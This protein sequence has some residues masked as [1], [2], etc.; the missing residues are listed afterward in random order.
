MAGR[1]VESRIAALE[2]RLARARSG[3]VESREFRLVDKAGRVRAAVEMTRSGPRLA[4]MHEDGTVSL[5]VMLRP[6]GPS[7]R[8]SDEDGE[9]RVF[10][11][12]SNAAARLALADEHGIQRVFIGAGR[13]GGPTITIYDPD[14]RTV[15]RA[16]K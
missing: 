6:Q 4:M 14:Q 7:I 15:W 9:T 13:R 10:I 3:V 12:A 5:E 16:P 2:R 11:G 8:M 1:S